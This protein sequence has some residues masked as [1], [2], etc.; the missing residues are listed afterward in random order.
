MPGGAGLRAGLVDRR[1]LLPGPGQLRICLQQPGPQCVGELG[2]PRGAGAGRHRV[3]Q[4]QSPVG[5]PRAL[6]GSGQLADAKVDQVRE[7]D[8]LRVVA[9]RGCRGVAG[10]VVVAGAFGIAVAQVIDHVQDLRRCGRVRR[11]RRCRRF[12][13]RQRYQKRQRQQYGQQ[14]NHH[15][16]VNL[17]GCGRMDSSGS[18][19]AGA[20]ARAERE[21]LSCTGQ[22]TPAA[23]RF[24]VSPGSVAA[25]GGGHTR[26]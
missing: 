16:R 14:S 6:V 11:L 1:L 8:Q 13:V 15:G 26:R 25:V 3:F 20:A 9:R 17:G 7:L 19:P 22:L 12:G 4:R 5:Q 24:P 23:C 10:L 21:S 2:H 18:I